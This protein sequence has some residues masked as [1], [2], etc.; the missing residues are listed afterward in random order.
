[1]IT[2]GG[3]QLLS[4]AEQVESLRE[5]LEGAKI[6]GLQIGAVVVQQ[7]MAGAWDNPVLCLYVQCGNGKLTD[8]KKSPVFPMFY[9]GDVASLLEQRGL[10]DI[11]SQDEAADVIRT[12]VK[13]APTWI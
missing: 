2:V 8:E 3:K 5:L 7:R 9:C 11:I 6:I 1:M 4:P 10:I 12:W 13:F